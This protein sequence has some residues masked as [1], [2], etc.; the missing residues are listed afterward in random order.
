MNGTSIVYNYVKLRPGELLIIDNRRAI[1]ARSGF[2]AYYDGE[3]RWLQRI[4]VVRDL[5]TTNEEQD[6]SQRIN[7]RPW[8]HVPRDRTFRRILQRGFKAA[9]RR[10]PPA[11][12]GQISRT[13]KD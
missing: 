1:H 7:D 2:K 4:Y 9:V 12:V 5:V 3:D 6:R 10:L 11:L 8:R 13:E